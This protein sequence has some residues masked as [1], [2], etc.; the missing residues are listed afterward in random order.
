VVGLIAAS[1]VAGLGAAFFPGG[2]DGPLTGASLDAGTAMRFVGA[3]EATL[4]EPVNLRATM[5]PWGGELR[6][7]C[8]ETNGVTCCVVTRLR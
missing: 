4:N 7:N 8:F 2:P 5:P 1:G 6:L 3:P